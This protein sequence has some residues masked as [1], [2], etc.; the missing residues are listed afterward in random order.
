MMDKFFDYLAIVIIISAAVLSVYY[1]ILG[2]YAHATYEAVL[3]FGLGNT[4]ENNMRDNNKI[5]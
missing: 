1:V 4:F 3:F 2:D 5:Y